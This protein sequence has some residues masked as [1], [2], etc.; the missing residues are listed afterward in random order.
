M[1]PVGHLLTPLQDLVVEPK[2]QLQLHGTQQ[3]AAA[4]SQ[5]QPEQVLLRVALDEVLHIGNVD[6]L[7]TWYAQVGMSQPSL[8]AD[9]EA[10][11]SNCALILSINMRNWFGIRKNQETHL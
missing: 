6:T 9:A 5:Q 7:D 8:P 4:L 1:L 11:H 2:H 10:M 3:Q